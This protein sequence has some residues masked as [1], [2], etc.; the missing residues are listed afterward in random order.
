M[1]RRPN[2]TAPVS[3]ERHEQARRDFPFGLHY[4]DN[5]RST[6]ANGQEIKTYNASRKT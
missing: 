2:G 6:K 1:R 5:R 3:F 4:V